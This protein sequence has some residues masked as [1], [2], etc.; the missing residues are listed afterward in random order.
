MHSECFDDFEEEILAYLT[1]NW[2]SAQL[3][4]ETETA[5]HMDKERLRL[6]LQVLCLSMRKRP[7]EKG[8]WVSTT[9]ARGSGQLHLQ[10]QVKGK[11]KKKKGNEKPSVNVVSTT[12]RPRRSSQS[13]NCSQLSESPPERSPI[14]PL[15]KTLPRK[16]EQIRM[17]ITVTSS[18][19]RSGSVQISS[20]WTLL[21]ARYERVE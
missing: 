11:R 3:V 14:S 21:H 16:R 20:T 7:F 1:R 13:S 12:S 2:T 10:N 8:S 18:E 15:P 17:K 6:G 5:E 4:R 9:K 19:R